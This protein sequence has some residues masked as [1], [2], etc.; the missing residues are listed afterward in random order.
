MVLSGCETGAGL[1]QLGEGVLGF[2]RAFRIAGADTVISSLW[3]V[4]D[5]DTEAWMSAFYREFGRGASP[6]QA[7]H[8]AAL[9]QLAAKRKARESTNP[10]YWGA[11][12]AVGAR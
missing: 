4:R 3:P 8:R 2:R 7:A 12:L 5:R 11:F 9:R 6:Q 10:Y 1:L